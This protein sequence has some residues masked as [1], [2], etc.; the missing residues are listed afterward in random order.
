MTASGRYLAAVT[1]GDVWINYPWEAKFVIPRKKRFDVQVVYC[2]LT[3]FPPFV[4]FARRD[5]DEHDALATD[6]PLI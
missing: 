6:H 3:C 2:S 1:T 5:I 4:F